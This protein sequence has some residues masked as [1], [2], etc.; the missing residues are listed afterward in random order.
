MSPVRNKSS[1]KPSKSGKG[2]SASRAKAKPTAKTKR[3][4]KPAPASAEDATST[5]PG[6]EPEITEYKPV[7]VKKAPPLPGQPGSDGPAKKFGMK[8]NTF[9]AKSVEV[10]IMHGL[11]RSCVRTWDR[12]GLQ[13]QALM[14]IPLWLPSE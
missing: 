1:G 5:E 3:Q 10:V 13:T 4:S 12:H 2:T 11:G 6:T 7:S 14:E 9:L 8:S